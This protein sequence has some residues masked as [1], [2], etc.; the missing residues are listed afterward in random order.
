MVWS[1]H[2]F[3]NLPV[4]DVI[5]VKVFDLGFL[6]AVRPFVEVEFVELF[7]ERAAQKSAYDALKQAWEKIV[8]LSVMVTVMPMTIVI[9]VVLPT[10]AEEV[11]HSVIRISEMLLLVP[12]EIA[13]IAVIKVVVMLLLL[14]CWMKT[15]GISELRRCWILRAWNL[16]AALL[17]LVSFLAMFITLFVAVF[18]PLFFPMLMPMFVALLVAWL[19]ALFLLVIVLLIIAILL[20]SFWHF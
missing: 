11:V 1:E 16:D 4:V 2:L 8:F 12:S 17:A 14:M 5:V 15:L 6:F 3:A 20:F 7:N 19:W 18:V 9:V 10:V 13:L